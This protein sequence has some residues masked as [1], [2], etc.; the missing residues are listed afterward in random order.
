M[1]SWL[2]VASLPA[3]RRPP[4]DCWGF[5]IVRSPRRFS[6]KRRRPPL[7]AALPGRTFRIFY[8]KNR[9]RMPEDARRRE[10]SSAGA[11]S[12]AG[13][14]HVRKRS[15]DARAA[16]SKPVRAPLFRA[17][18]ART[19]LA[20]PGR[21]FAR[22]GA[23]RG[24]E[25]APVHV[26]SFHAA[27]RRAAQDLWENAKKAAGAVPSPAPAVCPGGPLRRAGEVLPVEE[28][29]KIVVGGAGILHIR[30]LPGRAHGRLGVG[31]GKCRP[32]RRSG[33]PV[34]SGASAG[35]SRPR[36][37]CLFPARDRRCALPAGNSG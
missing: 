26:L 24:M 37:G 21:P 7:R 8:E 15:L 34:R 23:L 3:V 2:S 22:A 32:R 29:L 11:P 9:P 1:T 10:N 28:M 19:P 14:P 33:T 13:T 25:I 17:G 4:C 30:R 16:M 6:L 18:H 31:P 35:R 12:P 27:S 36:R 5:S 20:C